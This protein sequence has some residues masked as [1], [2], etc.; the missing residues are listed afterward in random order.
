MNR[1][2]SLGS[3]NA[4][5][6]T[7]PKSRQRTGNGNR[8]SFATS[9]TWLTRQFHLF[10]SFQKKPARCLVARFMGIMR[11]S[12]HFIP[13]SSTVSDFASHGPQA[14]VPI[15]S[16]V[17]RNIT[18]IRFTKKNGAHAGSLATANTSC[19]S[20]QQ[21]SFTR[22]KKHLRDPWSSNRVTSGKWLK[23]LLKMHPRVE[24]CRNP[25]APACCRFHL[26]P[27][28]LL[29]V[30]FSHWPQLTQQFHQRHHPQRAGQVRPYE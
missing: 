9:L 17:P 13:P 20:V 2:L 14:K 19:A 11:L 4:H 1:A 23:G 27:P 30:T 18:A 25:T 28:G 3:A 26:A 22:A 21:P 6:T 29:A 15:C 16:V 8:N 10:S 24:S 12:G 5:F 7:D